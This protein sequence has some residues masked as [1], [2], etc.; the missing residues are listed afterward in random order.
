MLHVPRFIQQI[1]KG[2]TFTSTQHHQPPKEDLESRSPQSHV[3]KKNQDA[4]VCYRKQH[5]LPPSLFPLLS[6]ATNDNNNRNDTINLEQVPPFHPS[7][8]F[9]YIHIVPHASPHARKQLPC[10]LYSCTPQKRNP[11]YAPS[12]PR[13]LCVAFNV[14]QTVACTINCCRK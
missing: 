2:S 8:P 7:D 11:R 13:L 3:K 10:I 14:E 9:F 12:Q 5:P 6:I 4:R 1:F